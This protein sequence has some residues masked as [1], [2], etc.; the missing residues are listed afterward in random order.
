MQMSSI[1][2]IAA[3]PLCC[4]KEVGEGLISGIPAAMGDAVC[5][6]TDVRPHSTPLSTEKPLAGP[7]VLEYA[8]KKS[9]QG[10]EARA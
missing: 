3:G 5:G 10:E 9:R 7:R 8:A 2:D 6:T 4:T 1:F